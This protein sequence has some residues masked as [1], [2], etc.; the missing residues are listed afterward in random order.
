MGIRA[1]VACICQERKDSVALAPSI[2]SEVRFKPAEVR[3]GDTFASLVARSGA[4]DLGNPDLEKLF[5]SAMKRIR[6]QWAESTIKQ[7]ETGRRSLFA[8][9]EQYGKDF[10]PANASTVMLWTESLI[11]KELA[12]ATVEQYL[13]HVASMYRGTE[14]GDPTQHELVRAVLKGHKRTSDHTP[15]RAV[16]MREAHLLKMASEVDMASPKDTRDIAAIALAYFGHLR[17]DEVV[18]LRVEDIQE[19]STQG[20]KFLVVDITKSKADQFREGASI[21]LATAKDNPLSP[22]E[23]LKRWNVHRAVESEY[24]FHRLDGEHTG[25]KLSAKS[26]NQMVKRMAEK[27]GIKHSLTGHSARAGG[28]STAAAKNIDE[29]I[30]KRHGRWKSNAIHV[31]IEESIANRLSVSAAL[32]GEQAQAAIANAPALQGMVMGDL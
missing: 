30:L 29:R 32:L 9:C 20:T 22:D 1:C 10:F 11:Q 15:E 12:P 21:M 6:N 28:V 13:S 26:F 3:P 4:P 25:E 7:Y 2:L 8:F 5:E 31:Y 14:I 27:A 16:A 23:W 19:Y 24:V 18:N 17:G